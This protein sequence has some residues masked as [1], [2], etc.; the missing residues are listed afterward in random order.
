[1]RETILP[2]ISG[3]TLLCD[4]AP[5]TRAHTRARE[6][7]L[8]LVLPFFVCRV[9]IAYLSI[10]VYL[11]FSLSL[12]RIHTPRSSVESPRYRG[13][14]VG[15]VAEPVREG[16]SS[17]WR[18]LTAIL[19]RDVNREASG[20]RPRTLQLCA[21]TLAS[22]PSANRLPSRLANFTFQHSRLWWNFTMIICIYRLS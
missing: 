22:P 1:M 19:P 8:S 20:Y 2:K 17:R 3:I 11:C 5:Q 21:S 15:D 9:G 6:P 12:S 16:G 18:H 10:F 4:S 14:T 7:T 13:Y